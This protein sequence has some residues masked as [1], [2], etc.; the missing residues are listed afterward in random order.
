MVTTSLPTLSPHQ[1]VTVILLTIFP[2]L[3]ISVTYF[4]TGSLYF[5]TPS[6]IYPPPYPP[7][8]RTL[9]TLPN[10]ALQEEPQKLGTVRD[11]L[12][13]PLPSALPA[14]LFCTRLQTTWEHHFDEVVQ[15]LPFLLAGLGKVS[16]RQP[17]SLALAPTVWG[18]TAKQASSLCP[19]SPTSPQVFLQGF[20]HCH[21]SQ[22]VDTCPEIM[23][24]N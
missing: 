18:P 15:D 19:Q 1:G 16:L 13:W 22:Q 8:G 6:S 4:L 12:A 23:I 17:C 3:Y 2:I 11:G 7:L 20:P 21:C 10:T 9:I 5:L 14:S 24:I